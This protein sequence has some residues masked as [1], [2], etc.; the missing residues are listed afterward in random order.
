[1]GDRQP[2][3]VATAEKALLDLLY[4]EKSSD[5]E[6]YLGELRLEM[7]DGF[8]LDEFERLSQMFRSPKVRRA[9]TGVIQRASESAREVDVL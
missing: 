3:F 6:A 1:M 2:A 4:L 5:S 8:D 7:D 9:V